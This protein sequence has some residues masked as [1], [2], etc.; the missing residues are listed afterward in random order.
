MGFRMTLTVPGDGESLKHA[1]LRLDDGTVYVGPAPES[2]P[3][4]GLTHFVNL[5]VEDPD[6]HYTR[7]KAAGA[8]IVME[9]QLSS[10]GARFYAARDL[11]GALW[12][13]STYS[14]A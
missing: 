8:R 3:F 4:Q 7:A 1:E 13:V 2:A 5:K 6:A 11:E 14:P 10:F 12:W 9:P